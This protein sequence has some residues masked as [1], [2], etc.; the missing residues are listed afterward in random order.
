MNSS[1]NEEI[2]QVSKSPV[3]NLI[4][5]IYLYISIIKGGIYENFFRVST[6]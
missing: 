4:I 1:M 5:E 6:S 3:V 2:N